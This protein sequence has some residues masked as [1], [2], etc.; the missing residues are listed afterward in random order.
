MASIVR[1]NTHWNTTPLSGSKRNMG[2]NLVKSLTYATVLVSVLTGLTGCGSVKTDAGMTTGSIDN[3]YRARHP[4]N[5]AEAEHTL[6]VPVASGDRKLNLSV[7]D[8]IRGFAIDYASTSS[9]Y[10]QILVPQGAVN[11]AA[12]LR[13][14]G[15]IRA[16][17]V[18]SGVSKTKILQ[19]SY[20]AEAA[21]QSSPVRIS[22]IAITAQTTRCGEWPED[23]LSNSTANKNWHNFG[24]ASQQNFA[25]QIANPMDLVA[26]RGMTPIDAQRRAV[27][28]KTYRSSTE[29]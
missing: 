28:I 9:G 7:R 26:P 22:Y 10:V 27:V 1:N 3:D 12:A 21:D 17:L 2:M 23:L 24:C 8:A 4:V 25:A 11:S 13:A 6:D 16:L 15:E 14:S 29:Q 19:S 5:L 18:E 20:A